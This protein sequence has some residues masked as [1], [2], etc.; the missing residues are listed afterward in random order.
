MRIGYNIFRKN[1]DS[2]HNIS[3]QSADEVV[4]CDSYQV[5]N[6]NVSENVIV[7]SNTTK[8]EN[9]I[10]IEERNVYKFMNS[11]EP[12][13]LSFMVDDSRMYNVISDSN[14]IVKIDNEITSTKYLSRNT[15]AN[16]SID[17]EGFSHEI[18]EIVNQNKLNEPSTLLYQGFSYYEFTVGSTDAY[19]IT[20]DGLQE[21]WATYIVDDNMNIL[22]ANSNRDSIS[23]VLEANK[24]Y[25]LYFNNKSIQS[26]V[27]IGVDKSYMPTTSI[28]LSNQENVYFSFMPNLTNDYS[29]ETD[30]SVIQVFDRS[31]QMFNW[32]NNIRL[33]KDSLYFIKLIGNNIGTVSLNA[34]INKEIASINQE[35]DLQNNVHDV[36]MLKVNNSMQYKFNGGNGRFDVYLG[37]ELVGSNIGELYLEENKD[38]IIVDAYNQERF[39]VEYIV[40]QVNMDYTVLGEKG[41]VYNFTATEKGMYSISNFENITVYDSQ[42]NVVEFDLAYKLNNGNYYIVLN[43]NQSLQVQ[44]TSIP[45]TITLDSDIPQ[46]TP[47]TTIVNYGEDFA[48]EDVPVREDFLFDGWTYNGELV[49]D[50]IGNGFEDWSMKDSITLVARWTSMSYFLN[51]TDEEG[52]GYWLT[53]DGVVANKESGEILS[54]AIFFELIND[55][56]NEGYNLELNREGYYVNEIKSAINVQDGAVITCTVNVEW[57]KE[58]YKVSFKGKIGIYNSTLTYGEAFDWTNNVEPLEN[59]IGYDF[60]Q[61][62]VVD[63]ILT[64]GFNFVPDINGEISFNGTDEIAY[65]GEYIAKKQSVLVEI[66]HFNLNNSE[67]NG[68][69]LPDGTD[70]VKSFR[71]NLEVDKTYYIMHFLTSDKIAK[72]Y[73]L[74][75]ASGNNI[76]I[77]NSGDSITFRVAAEDFGKDVS[78]H[79]KL[80]TI[81]HEIT[82]NLDAYDESFYNIDVNSFKE[83][84]TVLDR[85]IK[86]PFAKKD[87][88]IFD[89]W[90][91]G[92][93]HINAG[94]TYTVDINNMSDLTFDPSWYEW[95]EEANNGFNKTFTNEIPNHRTKVTIDVSAASNKIDIIIGA[96]IDEVV[97]RSDGMLITEVFIHILSGAD[98][99]IIEL[100][101]C[102]FKSYNFMT[103][104]NK[105][106]L[107]LSE[108]NKTI[109]NLTGTNRLIQNDFEK[110]YGQ[111]LSSALRTQ[112]D[113]DINAKTSNASLYIKGG[114][115]TG[116]SKIPGV[117]SPQGGADG[118]SAWID[119]IAIYD[120]YYKTNIRANITVQGGDGANGQR[121]ANVITVVT[122]SKGIKADAGGEGGLPGFGFLSES[123]V[124]VHSGYTLTGSSG[125]P[126]NGGA[127]GT[128]GKGK[129]AEWFGPSSQEGGDGGNGGDGGDNLPALGITIFSGNI[130]SDGVNN[131]KYNKNGSAGG[132][133]GAGGLGGKPLSGELRP[134][135]SAGTKGISYDSGYISRSYS[136]VD[137]NLQYY[138]DLRPMTQL[139]F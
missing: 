31:G 43:I 8:I 22:N 13:N 128:G 41:I 100:D 102:N 119:S 110:G 134:S 44:K 92:N 11:D 101:N 7:N 25:K 45:V 139:P 63:T 15:T 124:V 37:G 65:T 66:R 9:D 98:T 89:G 10:I 26:N 91:F 1:G 46:S 70:A 21:V 137:Y 73:G 51:F 53:E 69:K 116:F 20:T 127:G 49:T 104:N 133:G 114:D 130:L 81:K 82:Y 12:I 74:D 18:I 125:D 83:Y 59:V 88:F 99:V 107:L 54:Q 132:A 126:G 123:N 56:L 58:T 94:S 48:I 75:T 111:G 129:D 40:Q 62:Q 32:T 61:W 95:V 121:S 86:L 42:Y 105:F 131:V 87:N 27:S 34:E 76:Y 17:R 85:K 23:Y 113:V 117:N 19:Q 93:S 120:G 3:S 2:Y 39:V 112:F 67:F 122:G 29:F 71:V 118:G 28:S 78:V 64:T 115:A 135:G 52:N 80:K 47:T 38:Y 109:I 96:G 103:Y 79:V 33:T 55:M 14:S 68:S 106:A 35:I 108:A 24:N 136:S 60:M 138:M 77:A 50:E 72:G 90:N 57:R 84:Y 16:I 6:N 30:A 5:Y 4:S 97:I 36:I